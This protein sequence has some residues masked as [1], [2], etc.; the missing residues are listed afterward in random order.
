M[1]MMF[2]LLCPTAGY[3][4]KQMGVPLKL[5]AMVNVNDIVHRTVTAGDFSMATEVTQTL[6]SAI[7][8]QV[9]SISWIPSPHHVTIL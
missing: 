9:H 6:A 7:D 3:I 5:V 1:S 8:I 2:P 4:V